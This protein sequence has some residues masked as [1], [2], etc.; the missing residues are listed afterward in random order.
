MLVQEVM[1]REPTTATGETTI[2][3][4]AEILAE[5][6]ISSLPV[7]D[8]HGRLCGVVS[9]ADLIREA[10][11]PDPRSHMFAVDHGEQPAP[12]TVE[13]VMTPH[14][15]TVH[16]GT[17]IAD[18][19]ELMTTTGVKCLPV[20]DDDQGLVGVISRSDLV[21]VRAR[22]DDVI[23]REVGA[24]FVSMGYRDWLVEVS[25]GDVEIEGPTTV[26]DRS[27]AQ[28]IASTIPGVLKVRVR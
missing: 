11:V 10:F 20:I 14:A 23:E 12:K 6:H 24:R 15:I 27:M 16:E 13:D 7:L 18:A 8:D 17:D 9:E 25:E 2:K 19:A 28:V 26:N 5:L 4:A 3:R 21:K 22:A 1:T